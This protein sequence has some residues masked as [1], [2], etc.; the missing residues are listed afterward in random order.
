MGNQPE[1]EM[2]QQGYGEHWIISPEDCVQNFCWLMISSEILLPNIMHGDDFII[3]D[4]S[5]KSPTKIKW[6]DI[7]G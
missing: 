3:Q 5:R 2:T 7:S 1:V 6:N 4:Q